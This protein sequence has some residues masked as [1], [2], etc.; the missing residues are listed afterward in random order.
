M[1]APVLC[2]LVTLVMVHAGCASGQTEEG[3]TTEQTPVDAAK[4]PLNRHV[5]ANTVDGLLVAIR[6]TGSIVTLAAGADSEISS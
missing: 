4:D 5:Q 1:K 3:R 6:I 2:G